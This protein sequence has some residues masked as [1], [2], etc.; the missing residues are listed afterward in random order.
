MEDLADTGWCDDAAATA[1]YVSS[2]KGGVL[3]GVLWI[4][5][6]P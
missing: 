1:A 5:Q 3:F 2:A 4:K 6:Y